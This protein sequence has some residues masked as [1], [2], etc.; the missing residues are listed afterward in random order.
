M[1]AFES[2]TYD[3]VLM[4]INLP[5]VNGLELTRQI[6]ALSDATKAK[7]P[8]IAISGNAMNYSMDEFKEAGVTEY[9]QKPL[10][11]DELVETVQKY[12]G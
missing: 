7:V 5:G 10:D 8:I 12:T 1:K 2:D 3:I 6:R 9:I 4:D 11:F